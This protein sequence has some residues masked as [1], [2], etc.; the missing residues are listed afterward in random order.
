MIG[1]SQSERMRSV[2]LMWWPNRHNLKKGLCNAAPDFFLYLDKVYQE[3]NRG[4]QNHAD[5]RYAS[6]IVPSAGSGPQSR[7]WDNQLP[8]KPCRKRPMPRFLILRSSMVASEPVETCWD[9]TIIQGPSKRLMV[10][11]KSLAGLLCWESLNDYLR[12]FASERSFSAFP[13]MIASFL[14]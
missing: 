13:V 6:K 12:G 5:I 3:R 11:D 10:L 4:G 7:L 8:F 14:A 1:I 9:Q 2:D